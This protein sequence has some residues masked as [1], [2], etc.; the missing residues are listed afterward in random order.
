MRLILR[1]HLLAHLLHWNLCEA[2]DGGYRC[3]GCG[4]FT[5]WEAR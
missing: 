3:V 4:R 1:R 5:P 2:V